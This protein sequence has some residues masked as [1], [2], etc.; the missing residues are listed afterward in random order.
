MKQARNRVQWGTGIRVV[1][2]P[3]SFTWETGLNL[4]SFSLHVREFSSQV[5]YSCSCRISIFEVF[6]CVLLYGEVTR[7]QSVTLIVCQLP[8]HVLK[9]E[10]CDVRYKN[11]ALCFNISRSEAEGILR[12]EVMQ[13]LKK[14]RL[15]K[16]KRNRICVELQEMIKNYGEG[17]EVQT[18][19]WWNLEARD[20][21]KRWLYCAS[22]IFTFPIPL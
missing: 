18:I 9:C 14:G 21:Q 12:L 15:A 6:F 3:G 10:Y 4:D 13:C 8:A 20:W 5:N 16:F 11:L 17:L 22:K 1:G 2:P 7:G 19:E